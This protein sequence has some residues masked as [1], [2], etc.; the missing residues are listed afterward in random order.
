MLPSSSSGNALIYTINSTITSDMGHHMVAVLRMHP[1]VFSIAVR[2]IQ[3]SGL[4]ETFEEGIL[5]HL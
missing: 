5:T 1:S 3:I 2:A 4:L